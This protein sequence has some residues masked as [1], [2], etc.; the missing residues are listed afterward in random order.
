MLEAHYLGRRRYAPVLELQRQLVRQRQRGEISDR[1]LLVEHE[2]VIT[3]GRG[4]KLK[5]LLVDGPTLTA[6][7]VELHEIERGGDVTFHGP[8]QLV[9]Y[10][11]IHLR[12]QKISGP[13]QFV[14]KLEEALIRTL[15]EYGVDA[16]RQ[17]DLI[18]VWTNQGK[19]AAIGVFISQG[20]TM[21]GFALNVNTNLEYFQLIIPC[22]LSDRRVTSLSQL[23]GRIIDLREVAHRLTANFARVFC[24]EAVDIIPEGDQYNSRGHRPR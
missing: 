16:F 3:L 18:G 24:Y 19:V 8:G 21:H 11:I 9:G 17:P 6:L 12:E 1:L 7:G 4:A 15:A 14:Y 10:P 20:V 23:L 5:N 13:R 22:G 2:P